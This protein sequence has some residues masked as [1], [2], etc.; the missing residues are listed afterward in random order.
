MRLMMNSPQGRM[1]TMLW[2]PVNLSAQYDSI[3]SLLRDLSTNVFHRLRSRTQLQKRLVPELRA[4]NINFLSESTS[5]KHFFF[6][7]FQFI[8]FNRKDIG[9]LLWC[10]TCIAMNIHSCANAVYPRQFSDGVKIKIALDFHCTLE[11]ELCCAVVTCV[12]CVLGFAFELK[13]YE[14]RGSSLPFDKRKQG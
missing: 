5:E 11:S 8:S 13:G 12:F 7:K 2:S 3:S 14:F 1:M 10:K 6:A 9:Y 4:M